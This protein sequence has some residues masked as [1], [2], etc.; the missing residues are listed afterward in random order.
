MALPAG[1]ARSGGMRAGQRSS[2]LGNHLHK[3]RG[4]RGLRSD[5]IFLV[6]ESGSMADGIPRANW[7]ERSGDYRIVQVMIDSEPYLWFSYRESEFVLHSI[8][9]ED[10][11]R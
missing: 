10:T 2:Q 8:V 4:R 9:L 3:H 5:G 6:G 7:S 1:G 11:L